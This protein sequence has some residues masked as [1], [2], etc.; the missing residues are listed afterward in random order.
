MKIVYSPN[1]EVDIGAHVF[2]TKKY[3]LIYEALIERDILKRDD[4]IAPSIPKDE[5]ILLVHTKA[6]LEKLKNGTFSDED[7]IKLELPYSK[8]LAEASL[9]SAGGTILA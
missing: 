1:Y 9:L 8:E 5:D 2:P 6:Y 3:R 7:I 4:F